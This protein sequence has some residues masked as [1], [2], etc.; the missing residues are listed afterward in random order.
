MLTKNIWKDQYIGF[1]YSMLCYE[2]AMD[3]EDQSEEDYKEDVKEINNIRSILNEIQFWRKA[4]EK[5]D[6]D[7]CRRGRWW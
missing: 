3:Q 2:Y 5:S 4:N 6:W 1:R 7:S